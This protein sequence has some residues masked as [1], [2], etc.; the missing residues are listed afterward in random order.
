MKQ[1][2]NIIYKHQKTSRKFRNTIRADHLN[3]SEIIQIKDIEQSQKTI[4]SLKT[5]ENHINNNRN[6]IRRPYNLSGTQSETKQ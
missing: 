3:I 4:I 1:D 6:T 2:E 5:S